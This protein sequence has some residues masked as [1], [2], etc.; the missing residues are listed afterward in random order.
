MSE[1][2]PH[3]P[4]R[5][6]GLLGTLRSSFLTGLVVVLPVGLTIYLIWTVVGWIDGW[7]L[8][9]IPQS[10]QPPELIQHYLCAPAVDGVPSADAV[11]FYCRERRHQRARRRGRGVSGVHHFRRLDRPRA[12]SVGR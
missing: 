10:F 12:S 4:Q 1:P 3:P 8:P 6:R 7:V 11:P 9:F 5:R 2:H